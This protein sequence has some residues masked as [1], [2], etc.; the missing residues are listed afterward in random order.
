MNPIDEIFP[1][2]VNKVS[3]RSLLN[4]NCEEDPTRYLK[5]GGSAVRFGQIISHL[6]YYL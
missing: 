6:F 3:Q 1:P 4:A 2:S 5:H